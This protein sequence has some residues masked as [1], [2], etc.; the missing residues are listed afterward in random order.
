MTASQSQMVE[1][2]VS[3]FA[4]SVESAASHLDKYKKDHFQ[5]LGLEKLQQTL[6]TEGG[7]TCSR[8]APP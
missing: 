6:E 4:G 5:Q 8:P 1:C 7:S 3:M 2:G